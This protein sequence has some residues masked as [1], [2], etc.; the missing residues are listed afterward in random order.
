MN[1]AEAI[2]F[3]KAKAIVCLLPLSTAYY[4][5]HLIMTTS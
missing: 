1:C 5:C 3:Q 4:R 2:F